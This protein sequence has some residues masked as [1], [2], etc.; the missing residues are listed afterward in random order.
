[1]D[2]T[3]TL[4]LFSPTTEILVLFQETYHLE[5]SEKQVK[6][7]LKRWHLAKNFQEGDL[8]SLVKVCQ[9][10][11]DDSRRTFIYCGTEKELD[12]LKRYLQSKEWPLT[13]VLNDF[14][15]RQ[16]EIHPLP[17][18]IQIDPPSEASPLAQ[19]EHPTVLPLHQH[20][21][22][23]DPFEEEPSPNLTELGS[24]LLPV[25]PPVE[26]GA[27]QSNATFR[28]QDTLQE[29]ALQTS[30]APHIANGGTATS[31]SPQG[32]THNRRMPNIAWGPNQV[33]DFTTSHV[34]RQQLSEPESSSQVF[35][36][37]SQ[38]SS[39]SDFMATFN[40]SVSFK[41]FIEQC[42]DGGAGQHSFPN[43]LSLIKLLTGRRS[44]LDDEDLI[45]TLGGQPNLSN[46]GYKFNSPPS[47]DD[48]PHELLRFCLSGFVLHNKA[49]RALEE[50]AKAFF[51]HAGEIIETMIRSR[52][53][54]CIHVLHVLS[55]LVDTFGYNKE[56]G[57]NLGEIL[58]REY[59]DIDGNP[60]SGL[61]EFMVRVLS[62]ERRPPDE[63][64]ANL[65][66]I[67]RG[68]KSDLD[69][70]PAIIARWNFAWVCFSK[71]VQNPGTQQRGYEI[72]EELQTTLHDILG[73]FDFLTITCRATFARATLHMHQ[74]QRRD[75][76]LQ[77]P[78]H[79]MEAAIK[80]LDD[81][82]FHPFHPF[83]LELQY[84]LAEY[85]IEDNQKGR[86]VDLLEHVA[87]HRADILGS[88]NKR[89][90]AAERLLGENRHQVSM[91]QAR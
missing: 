54:R 68:L 12:K 61:M 80:D 31:I 55:T 4:G 6:D 21:R 27:W 91:I 59:H 5:N 7:H 44:L 43:Q 50:P 36:A 13:R 51:Q 48:L 82:H 79:L 23:H 53:H 16:L 8:E 37:P 11:V 1:M 25:E 3:S 71:G 90:K 46:S 84:R 52:N 58:V 24:P 66:R 76:P 2:E 41:L 33:G 57:F 64:L 32:Q 70:I 30:S 34:Y 74:Q 75:N 18:W 89:T 81:A 40:D 47:F 60:V 9:I 65:A 19:P 73:P 87:R 77:K 45:A 15:R 22:T 69:P 63:E 83:R 10:L 67:W 56:M 20:A 49:P 29:E 62:R 42:I 14:G 88:D 86:A 26:F 85:F 17:E 72:F 28:H 39:T 78:I 35:S 38:V